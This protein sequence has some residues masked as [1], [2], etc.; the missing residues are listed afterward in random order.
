[1]NKKWIFGSTIALVAI[2]GLTFLFKEEEI[3]GFK[4]KNRH[5][6]FV[7][8]QG[9][10]LLGFDLVDP[11][12]AP[13]EIRQRVMEGYRFIMNTPLYAPEYAGDQLSCTHCHFLGGDTLGGKNNGISL[14]GVT[15]VYPAQ[16]EGRVITLAE[17][18]NNCFERS[19]NG[20]PLPKDSPVM[21]SI[22]AYLDWISKEVKSVKHI[23]WLGI[24]LLKSQHHANPDEG[25][26]LYQAY[27]A[28]CHQP[29]GEG[30]GILLAQ[31]GKTIPPLWG[32]HSF[33]NEAGMS[34]LPLLSAFIYWNMPYQE[35]HLS[36]EQAL[37]IAAFI[38]TK[39]R[40]HFR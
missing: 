40:P 15:T 28:E 20:K 26:K 25:R 7:I 27:C 11:E 2:S 32:E 6:M 1:M 24:S 34:T 17:R 13:A 10:T 19:L 9:Q 5:H 39:P 33:N 4:E 21:Q 30:G 31:E 23:P 22:L 35:A 8:A 3:S 29:D 37:D 18:I 12:Q 36:E 38:L 14:V 16:K